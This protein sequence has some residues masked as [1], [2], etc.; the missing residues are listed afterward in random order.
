M[1]IQ[2]GRRDV[3]VPTPVPA[4]H[5]ALIE[6]DNV[7][8]IPSEPPRKVSDYPHRLA[9]LIFFAWHEGPW[10][11]WRKAQ[12]VL[13]Q[14]RILKHQKVV[15]V[16]GK[17]VP[18]GMPVLAMGVQAYPEAVYM[19]FPSEY[20]VEAHC[21]ERQM[22][23]IRRLL[24]TRL[25]EDAVLFDEVWHY[26]PF[27]GRPLRFGLNTLC[28]DYRFKLASPANNF[29]VHTA[30]IRTRRKTE[31]HKGRTDVIV[32]GAGSYLLSY[33]LPHFRSRRFRLHTVVDLNP[34][35]AAKV[36]D[37]YGF[38][39]AAA[40]TESA[41][42][43][44]PS[45]SRPVLIIATYHSTHV[46]VAETAHRHCPQTR[47][48]IEKPPVTDRNQLATLA[49]LRSECFIEIGYNRRYAPFVRRAKEWIKNMSG[50][51]T[52]TCIVKELNIPAT[53]WYYWPTQGTRLTGNL[54]HWIDLGVHFISAKPKIATIQS[55]SP[56]HFADEI[57]ASI[58]FEDGS[59]LTLVASDRGNSTQ[60]VQECIEI[61]R[62]DA[63]VRIDDFRRLTLW[64]G[65][66]EKKFIRRIRDKGH[67]A[68]YH[69]FVDQ[70]AKNEPRAQY[71]NDDL[72]KSS[73]LYLTMVDM[74]RDGKAS[75][76]L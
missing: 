61:R 76:H 54:S 11:T 66:R 41:F 35:R 58:S 48:F 70:L 25:A 37:A 43:S 17:R 72:G 30:P 2:S 19:C 22:E 1:D 32:A 36:A 5:E 74:L 63:T 51:T 33:V 56:S 47:M 40:S 21:D 9:K 20:V 16:A 67:S 24:S 27:S 13:F 3:P 10:L 6:C 46:A 18:D 7:W 73:L 71:S 60:G 15:L 45:S 34:L 4:S 59:L 44:L 75:L 12:A 69:A 50:P 65:G 29:P 49:G 57:S 8:L 14:Q 62:G 38:L 53:H 31:I 23:D 42:A 52:I 68:M 64:V 28:P 39:Y 55:A 26:S